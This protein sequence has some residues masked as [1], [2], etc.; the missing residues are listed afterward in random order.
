M[1]SLNRKISRSRYR[2][3]DGAFVLPEREQQISLL[4]NAEK[5]P[6]PSDWE[7]LKKSGSVIS[8]LDKKQNAFIKIYRKNGFWR[9]L[10]RRFAYPRSFRCLAGALRLEELQ[11]PTPEVW[12]AS[13]YELV[14]E[15]LP[16]AVLFLNRTP[17]DPEKLMTLVTTL[18]HGGFIHG[19]LNF[20]NIY[21]TPDGRYGLIDLDAVLLCDG[22]VPHRQRMKELG[23]SISSYLQYSHVHSWRR[24]REQTGELCALYEEKSHLSCRRDTV[25]RIVCA[26]LK[27]IFTRYGV[28]CDE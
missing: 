13:R 15:F 7:L 24:I 21:Q 22:I 20:R 19:D 12:Y 14:T 4:Q 26:H 3:S 2:F 18:H 6:L 27:H 8:F 1:G 17:A 10:K 16:A 11:I 28:H 23:R 9:T 5:V 25:E